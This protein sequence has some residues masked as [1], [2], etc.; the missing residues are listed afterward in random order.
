M[1]KKE[2][3]VKQIEFQSF[4]DSFIVYL[5]ADHIYKDIA[6]T[7]FGNSNYELD[8]RMPKGK[9]KK[10]IGLMKKELDGKIMTKFVKLRGKC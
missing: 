10:V 1:V 5:K 7:R 6:E 9:N 4:L 2:N 8:R 3:C